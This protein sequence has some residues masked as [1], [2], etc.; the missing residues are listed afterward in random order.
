MN[1]RL[2]LLV[3][4]AASVR[5]VSGADAAA[6]P[7]APAGMAAVP[8]GEHRPLFILPNEP[9]KVPVARFAVDFSPCD[10]RDRWAKTSF[11]A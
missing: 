3:L 2:I 9:A 8:A 10:C 11:P 7:E 1:P 5:M 6:A 4:A